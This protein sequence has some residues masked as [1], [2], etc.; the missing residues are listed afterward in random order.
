MLY[1]LCMLGLFIILNIVA[2]EYIHSFWFQQDNSRIH[3]TMAVKEW[4][5]AAYFPV[6]PWPDRSSGLNIMENVGGY[7]I[8][9]IWNIADLK[10]EIQKSFLV[11][12]KTKIRIIINLYETFR[13]RLVKVIVNNGNQINN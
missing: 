8:S 13:G 12:N 11:I 5:T 4:K 7:H 1:A 9:A 6:L 2:V 10:V 3:I